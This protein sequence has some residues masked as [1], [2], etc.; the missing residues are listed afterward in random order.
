VLIPE[1]INS[2]ELVN[3]IVEASK[4]Q[5]ISVENINNSIQQLTEITNKNSTSAEEM[6]SSA[7][8]LSAQAE[9][10]KVM[11][12]I[13]KIDNL[14]DSKISENKNLEKQ[15]EKKIRDKKK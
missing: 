2:A 4:E 3:N 10:L 13:F 11:I 6:S 12:S 15:D 1:I 14:E 5:E 9:Q 8:Q 7:E